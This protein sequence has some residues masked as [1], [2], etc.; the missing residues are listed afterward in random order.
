[1]KIDD[2][3]RQTSEWLR[4]KGPHSEIVLSSRVRLARNLMNYPF[5][6][7]ADKKQEQEVLEKAKKAIL[8]SPD[9]KGSLILKLG[10][11]SS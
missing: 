3:L 1:M 2:F 5:S 9:L 11:L 10:D 4:G 8:A 7:W 6:H